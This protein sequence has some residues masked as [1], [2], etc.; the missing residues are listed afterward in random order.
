MLFSQ[1]LISVIVPIYGVE[2]YLSECIESILS[3]TYTN[4]EIILVNDG[5]KDN[6]PSICDYYASIDN[7]ILVLHKLNGGLVSARKEGLK[8]SK[9]D[10]IAYID[11]DDWVEPEM[12]EEML[13]YA[14]KYDVD[15]V[16]GGHKEELN[17]KVVEVLYNNL[18]EGLYNGL[19][20]ENEIFPK[21]LNTGAFSKFGIFSYLW[22][23]L[24]KRSIIYDNQLAVDD[25]IFMAEDAACTYPTLLDSKSIYISNSAF[26]RYRQ[27]VDSMVKT[28]DTT[29]LD[30]D[31][32]NVLY[33]FLKK[34]FNNSNCSEILKAQLDLFLLSILTVRSNLINFS[35]YSSQYLFPFGEI[36]FGS[37]I[38]ILGAGT[39]GQHLYHR[40]KSNNNYFFVAW[41]D[42]LH[43]IYNDLGLDV[44]SYNVLSQIE[45]DVVLVAYIDSSVS[46][47]KKKIL[48]DLDVPITK[49][50]EVNHYKTTEATKILND[51]GIL[52]Q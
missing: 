37:K 25:R 34:R 14:L 33:H 11:G 15:I 10:Y 36:E 40:I 16:V 24:F 41:I 51:F 30:I 9:G 21:M 3:Q 4:L 42:D 39:F 44:D 2:K 7:R 50:Y 35:N 31:K 20:L 49:I 26:Y 1:N 12:Y 32:Y 52:T 19:R 5:S 6:C 17:G 46:S 29:Y 28:R 27:R 48:R 8:V 18:P 45:Y 47:K 22:N 23:K 38:I 13:K 43:D